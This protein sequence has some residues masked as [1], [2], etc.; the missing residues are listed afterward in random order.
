M[1]INAA[2]TNYMSNASI[3]AWMEQKT[4]DIYGK[5]RDAMDTSTHR[6]DAENALNDVKS[7]FLEMK[8][9]GSNADDVRALI[10][11]AKKTVGVEFPEATKAL[12]DLSSTLDSKYSAALKAAYTPA[13]TVYE[14]TGSGNNM[15]GRTVPGHQG[16]PAPV[17]LSKDELDAF[18]TK[19]GN[20]VDGMGKADQLGMINIQEFN[21]QLNQAKQTASALMD[22][23]DKSAS[24]IINHIS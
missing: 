18:S 2:S 8:A 20:V 21:A 11:E 16:T 24:A 12:E 19:L 23:A 7:K 14:S 4:E 22:S 15:T 1:S 17:I 10:D 3:E 6:A 5:M 9:N 13:T